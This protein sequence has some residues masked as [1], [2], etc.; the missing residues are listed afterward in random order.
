[1]TLLLEIILLER[2]R[3]IDDEFRNVFE[4][5]W[6]SVVGE[7]ERGCGR[8]I[9]EHEG[10]VIDQAFGEESWQS[11]ECIVH[12]DRDTWDGSVGEDE[13]GTDITEVILNFSCNTLFVEGVL[14]K[15]PSIG[16]SR[17]V[18]DVNLRTR[19]RVLIVFTDFVAHRYAVFT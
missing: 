2:D 1:M 16:Q 4:I 5:L 15:T 9:C 13:N 11:R 18:E 14:L 19:S 12:A 8:N 17:R 3:V 6:D 10:N 7:V